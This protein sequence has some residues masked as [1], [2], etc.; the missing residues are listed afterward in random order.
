MQNDWQDFLVQQGGIVADGRIAH[1]GDARR[2]LLAARDATVVCDLSHRGLILASGE[3]AQVFLHGQFTNDVAALGDDSA[4]LNG[5]CSP[6]GRLLATFLMWKGKQGFMLQLPRALV[7]PIQK[8]LSM[9]V[10]RS[11][12]KLEDVSDQWM[13]IGVAGRAAQAKVQELFGAIPPQGMKTLHTDLGRAI[14]LSGTRFELICSPGNAQRIWT[15]LSKET[16]ENAVKAGCAAWDWLEIRDGIP[17]VLPATQEAFVPQMANFELV[18]GVSFKKGCYPGQ[19][20]VARTQYR[21]IL[22]RRMALAH[23]DTLETPQPGESVYSA[24]FGDQAA[25]QIAN[26]APSPEGGFDLLVVA[27]IEGIQGAA[28]HWKR[29][30]GSALQLLPLPYPMPE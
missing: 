25:G 6:K 18:G 11:K 24:Q 20:I 22:K 14:R 4:Q 19:E 5:Y 21:G 16:A 30:D 9:F 17:T 28:L 29:P 3:D 26:A 12:V 13:R 8:R 2:E 7:A 10:L 1:F 23:V 27:Q 15:A